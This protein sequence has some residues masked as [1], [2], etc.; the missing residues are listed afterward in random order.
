MLI[1]TDK[2][3]HGCGLIEPLKE[4]LRA[5]DIRFAIFDETVPNP[6]VRNVEDARSL[7]LNE[8]CQGIIGFA[9]ARPWTAP[10]WWARASCGPTSR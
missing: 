9:A 5:A 8:G 7:Y 10:R 6:T 4:A 1:V 2:S 3:I